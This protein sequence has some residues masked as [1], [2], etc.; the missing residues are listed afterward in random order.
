VK[1][2]RAIRGFP[3]KVSCIFRPARPEFFTLSSII[4]WHHFQLLRTRSIC[5]YV[6]TA[7]ANILMLS[8]KIWRRLMLTVQ[9]HVADNDLT[10]LM[11]MI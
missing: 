7:V 11:M 5:N 9:T 8:T 10:L 2:C 3:K 4:L 6:H 1:E